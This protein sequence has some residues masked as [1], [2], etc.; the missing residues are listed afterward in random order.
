MGTKGVPFGYL[1]FS[2]AI[3]GKPCP[4]APLL[5]APGQAGHGF[6]FGF[7]T[8]SGSFWTG[9]HGYGLPRILPAPPSGSEPKAQRLSANY[10]EQLGGCCPK[11]TVATVQTEPLQRFRPN[12]CNR[13]VGFGPFYPSRSA[14]NSAPFLSIKTHRKQQQSIFCILKWDFYTQ[15][16]GDFQHEVRIPQLEFRSDFQE[17][18]KIRSEGRLKKFNRFFNRIVVWIC[19]FQRRIFF[20]LPPFSTMGAPPK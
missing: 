5:A 18:L 11:R 8:R 10:H 19:D 2:R 12:R 16:R 14:I 13:S 6:G 4:R 17:I 20:Y 7:P 15:F 1:E 9:S 3:R